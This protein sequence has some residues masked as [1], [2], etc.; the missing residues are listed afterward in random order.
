MEESPPKRGVKIVLVESAAELR[1]D[2]ASVPHTI[3]VGKS[4]AMV[5]GK[6]FAG[7]AVSHF[8]S[9]LRTKINLCICPSSSGQVVLGITVNAV[10]IGQLQDMFITFRY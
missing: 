3:A 1:I 10:G 4:F 8:T 9:P 7:V 5:A 2:Q 6:L